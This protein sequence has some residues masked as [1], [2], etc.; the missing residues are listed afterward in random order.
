[1]RNELTDSEEKE[2]NENPVGDAIA[3]FGS[4]EEPTPGGLEEGLKGQEE[5]EGGSNYA[6]EKTRGNDMM[7][8]TKTLAIKAGMKEEWVQDF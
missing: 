1:M 3:G 5:R 7:T 8:K 6:A 4:Q 2:L